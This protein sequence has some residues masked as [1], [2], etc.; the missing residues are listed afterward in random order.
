MSPT[1]SQLVR[2]AAPAALALAL[3]LNGMALAASFTVSSDKL[4]AITVAGGVTAQTCTLTAAAADVYADEGSPDGTSGS[5][6]TLDVR[7]GPSDRRTFVRFDLA[8]C[9]IPQGAW[10]SSAALKLHLSTAPSSSRSY[11]AHRTTA[12]WSEATATWNNQA[13]VAASATSSATTG[14]TTGATV[15]WPVTADV[16]SFL[17]GTASNHGWRIRDADETDPVGVGAT[18]SSREHATA[19][20]RPVLTI[21]YYP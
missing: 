4:T 1:L 15:E 19:G 21:A 12:G 20:E 5:A 9:S 10:V 11:E 7:S 6:T 14:T 13:P 18:F 17:D 16:R 2:H 8:G 3:A